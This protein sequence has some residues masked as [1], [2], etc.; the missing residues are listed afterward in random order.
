[1]VWWL[2]FGSYW[3]RLAALQSAQLYSAREIVCPCVCHIAPIDVVMAY[4]V[5]AHVCATSPQSANDPSFFF[6][7]RPTVCC[8]CS[9]FL[10]GHESAISV[11]IKTKMGR[12][13]LIDSPSAGLAAE[14]RRARLT[15]ACMS[16]D[17]AL[18]PSATHRYSTTACR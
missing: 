12:R 8:A 18:S 14:R 5:M 11:G 10:A 15:L 1:M 9:S 7:S 2:R 6:G 4:I 16:A 13:A 3:R 17:H